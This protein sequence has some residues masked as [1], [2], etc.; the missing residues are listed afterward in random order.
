MVILKSK[1]HILRQISAGFKICL[2]VKPHH[3]NEMKKVM[4]QTE[5][6]VKASMAKPVCLPTSSSSISLHL[7]EVKK[8]RGN[9]VNA[10]LIWE[11]EKS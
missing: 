9:T 5:L 1:A 10:Y 7:S 3:P 4:E 6:R 2:A 8:I 11:Q